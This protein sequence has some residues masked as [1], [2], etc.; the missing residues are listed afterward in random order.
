M[1][2][3]KKLNFG[4]IFLLTLHFCIAIQIQAQPPTNV[5][6]TAL[7][8]SKLVINYSLYYAIDSN[9]LSAVSQEDML[10]I[11]GSETSQFISRNLHLYVLKL[12]ESEKP[13]LP[14]DWLA[15]LND[16]MPIPKIRYNIFK[17][18]PINKITYIERIPSYTFAYEE[19]VELFNWD[20]TSEIDSFQGFQVQKALTHYGGRDW[21]AWFSPEIP[22]T[23]GPYKFCGLPGLILK[24]YDTKHHY[25]FE[26]TSI[27]H[28]DKSIDI[29]LP[30][31][32]FVETTREGFLKAKENFRSDIIN[33]AK[34]A[35]LGSEAQQAAA[36]NLEK[37]NNPI[38]LR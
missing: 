32:S 23:E 26:M 9:N 2:N 12:K 5:A 11:I 1:K 22:L 8:T 38:E 33:R 31:A 7:D 29:E 34:E 18:F 14:S 13:G 35:G 20:L 4:I 10:L 3:F 15:N 17:N 24:I 28:L 27:N 30:D 25:T 6:H 16:R 21:I 36:R 37:R 19:S